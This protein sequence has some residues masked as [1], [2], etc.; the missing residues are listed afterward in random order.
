MAAAEIEGVGACN[1]M[2][3][4]REASLDGQGGGVALNRSA[5]SF[6]AH[7]APRIPEHEGRGV[8]GANCSEE[9][10]DGSCDGSGTASRQAGCR[11]VGLNGDGL[12]QSTACGP[13]ARAGL[14]Q[15]ILRDHDRGWSSDGT[16]DDDAEL[17]GGG[18]EGTAT[19][20]ATSG[21]KE[22]AGLVVHSPMEAALDVRCSSAVVTVGTP[23]L[24]GRVLTQGDLLEAMAESVVVV[25][26]K[27]PDLAR[28]CNR[29]RIGA[30]VDTYEDLHLRAQQLQEDD[31]QLMELTPRAITGGLNLSD[32]LTMRAKLV[33][34]L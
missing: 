30:I 29:N 33:D 3:V 12:V 9:A 20:Q 28:I 11:L 2:Q 26:A 23:V 14:R 27:L 18:S 22:R 1:S 5:S 10:V 6:L 4:G 7:C 34:T 15:Q 19:Q 8:R 21:A 25:E 32:Q 17:D 16:R 13:M 31:Q 24:D